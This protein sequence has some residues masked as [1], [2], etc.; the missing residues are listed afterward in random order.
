MLKD[1]IDSGTARPLRETGY[2]GVVAGKTGTSNASADLW[3]VGYTPQIV[4]T[5]WIGFDQPRTIV[6]D[7]ESGAI[8]APIWGRIMTRFDDPCPDWK[9]PLR[10]PAGRASGAAH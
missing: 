9:V 8:T 5:I 10:D 4:G 2:R 3:F 1:V 7:A 6:T